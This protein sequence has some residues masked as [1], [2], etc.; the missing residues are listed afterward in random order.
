MTKD[1]ADLT[2]CAWDVSWNG[3]DLGYVDDVDP[4]GLEPILEEKKV[5]SLGDIVLGHW[6]IGLKGMIKS[7]HRQLPVTFYQAVSPWWSS[8]DI[9]LTPAL[10]HKDFYD[11]A[12]KL[13]LH[14]NHIAAGTKTLDITLLKAVPM[15]KPPKRN[16]KPPELVEINWLL[17]PDRSQLVTSGSLIAAFGYIGAGP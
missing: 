1:P 5:G 14:P 13:V 12:Q 15:F 4:T 2:L 9:A 11:Y 17:Y 10:W 3:V 6:I 16:N 8:G 7:Q